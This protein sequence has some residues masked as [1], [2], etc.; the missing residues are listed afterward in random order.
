MK[1]PAFVAAILLMATSYVLGQAKPRMI[2]TGPES[3][4]EAKENTL[5]NGWK[6]TPAGRHVGVNSMPLKMAI[7]PDG[8]TLA[9]VCSGR[10]NG[11]ALID[12]KT[13]QTKQW[14]PLFRTFNGVAFSNDGKKIFVTGGN[15]QDLFVL[16]FDGQKAGMVQTI[17]LGEQSEGS[18]TM[19]F[20]AGMG[21]NPKTGKLYVCNEGTS[22]IWVVDSDAQKVEAKWETGAHP[23]SCALGIDGRY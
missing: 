3:V 9:A 14:I 12:L 21:V 10:W 4:I 7:S 1:E 13:E 22:E 6:L 17:E 19:N 18:K 11:L 15:S 8:Q 20:L 2:P 5:F 23:Y 16:N